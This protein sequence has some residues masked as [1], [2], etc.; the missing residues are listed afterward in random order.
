MTQEERERIV[1]DVQGNVQRITEERRKLE[2]QLTETRQ[3][4]RHLRGPVESLQE[5]RNFLTHVSFQAVS[6]EATVTELQ[7]AIAYQ[8][9]RFQTGLDELHKRRKG[10][11]DAIARIEE[12]KAEYL[13]LKHRLERMGYASPEEASHALVDLEIRSLSLRAASGAAQETLAA[14]RNMDM[15]AIYAQIARV[16]GAFL[17]QEDWHI[18][19]DSEGNP[20]L[21][22]GQ[23]HQFDLSQFSGGEKTALL[24]MLHTIIAHHFSQS[25]FLLID[26][27]LEHLDPV[28]RRSLIRF[29][30]GGYRR[31]SFQQAI[32]ATF[33][34]SLIR[35]YMSEEG[36]NV[37]HLS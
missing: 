4:Q 30:V 14:Q 11:E 21:E 23:G 26:E 28:N 16:W 33:E 31:R 8:Q 5:L 12:E 18:Q 9:E 7:K 10:F 32:I 35:K 24:V 27:P 19:L 6:Q 36:V 22:D 17:G 15:E 13:A 34:E 20:V 3:V 29:L 37:I 2:Q 25:N 1:S